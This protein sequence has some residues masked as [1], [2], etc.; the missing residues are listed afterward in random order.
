MRNMLNEKPYHN[1]VQWNY[2]THF[3]HN[4]WFSKKNI[5]LIG[6]PTDIRWKMDSNIDF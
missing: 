5:E 6:Q 2:L 4:Y 1:D 3:V